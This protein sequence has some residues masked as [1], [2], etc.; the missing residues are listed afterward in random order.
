MPTVVDEPV[1]QPQFETTTCPLCGSA[2]WQVERCLGDYF[3]RQP[4]NFWIVR[5]ERCQLR[6]QNPRPSAAVIDQ[7]YP[8]QYGSYAG[9]TQGL[10]GWRG[11]LGQIK[12][13]GLKVR[14]QRIDRAVPARQ[15]EMRRL[16]DIGCGGPRF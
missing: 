15:G 1:I 10:R 11:L 4:G 6:Y 7:Y 14:C 2:T 13:H 16:L 3:F 9:A 12:Q 5:C 8:D